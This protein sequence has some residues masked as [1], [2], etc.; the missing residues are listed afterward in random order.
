MRSTLRPN[1]NQD[2]NRNR[3]PIIQEMTKSL[4]VSLESYLDMVSTPW[5][6]MPLKSQLSRSTPINLRNQESQWLHKRS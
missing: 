6:P 4:K 2:Q 5:D 3:N 1:H